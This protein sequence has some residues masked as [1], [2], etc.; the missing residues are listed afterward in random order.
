M[1]TA[2]MIARAERTTQIAPEQLEQRDDAPIRPIK[3]AGELD[4]LKARI[5][6]ARSLTPEPHAVH[7]RDCF[8]KGRDA[9]IRALEGD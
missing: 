7:C 6:A 9:V 3:G 4:T 8:Q 1:G 5:E 2:T